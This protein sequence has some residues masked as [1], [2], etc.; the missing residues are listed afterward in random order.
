MKGWPLAVV[1]TVVL[2]LAF[3]SLAGLYAS[4]PKAKG[5]TYTTTVREG[6]YCRTNVFA[7]PG[8]CPPGDYVPATTREERRTRRERTSAWERIAVTGDP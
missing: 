6:G 3:L 5:V 4:G 2:V 8:E 7:E 1:L